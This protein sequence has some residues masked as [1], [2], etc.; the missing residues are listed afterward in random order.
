M[1]TITEIQRNVLHRFK[2][3]LS[4]SEQEGGF[5]ADAVRLNDV[6]FSRLLAEATGQ[7]VNCRGSA[8]VDYGRVRVTVEFLDEPPPAD[9]GPQEVPGAEHEETL[10]SG[11]KPASLVFEISADT[12]RLDAAIAR[13]RARLIELTEMLA[14]LGVVPEAP[15]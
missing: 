8:P 10:V 6:D 7:P 11:S 13:S 9:P 15:R 3:Q 2:G 4:T 1:T 14:R 12:S 5:A